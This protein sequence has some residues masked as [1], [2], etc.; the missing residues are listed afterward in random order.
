MPG[1]NVVPSALRNTLCSGVLVRRNADFGF[2]EIKHPTR[3]NGQHIFVHKRKVVGDF[4]DYVVGSVVQFRV[5]MT[6]T[7]KLEAHDVSLQSG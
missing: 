7:Q 4:A 5:Q 2:I 3:Y 1:G 6:R